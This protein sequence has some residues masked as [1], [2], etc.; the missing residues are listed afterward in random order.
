MSATGEMNMSDIPTRQ[1]YTHEFKMDALALVFE[2]G[3]STAE[4]ARH[5]GISIK[6]LQT[7]KRNHLAEDSAGVSGSS[8]D[9]EEIK[10]LRMQIKELSIERDIFKKASAYFAKAVL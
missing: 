1:T 3:Y 5:L 7:W 9:K 4:A 2:H 8:D 6:T 10:R